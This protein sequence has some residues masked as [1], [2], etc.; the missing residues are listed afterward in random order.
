MSIDGF[1]QIALFFLILPL[2]A[3]PLAA[4]MQRLYAGDAAGAWREDGGEPAR[5]AIATRP[6]PA[7]LRVLA[8]R[9]HGTPETDA[10]LSALPPHA[11]TQAGSSLK[12][13]RVAEGSADL[14]PRFGPTMG[15]DTAAGHAVLIAAGGCV[16][17]CDGAPLTYSA[18]ADALR[19]PDFLAAGSIALA[20][21]VLYA[22]PS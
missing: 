9:S 6:P 3:A 21:S 12:F 22:K 7:T 5:E 13:A 8:S 15:W 14:Y 20:R 1:A 17:T 16:V 11:C 18:R 19:N 2:L 10:F 4:W